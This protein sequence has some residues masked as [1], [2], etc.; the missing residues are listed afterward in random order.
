MGEYMGNHCSIKMHFILVLCAIVAPALAGRLPYIVGGQDVKDPGTYPWQ[1]SLQPHGS[2]HSCGASLVSQ[3]WLVTAAHCVGYS[4]SYYKVVLGMHDK[5]S[6]KNGS[7]V[8][9]D[10][11]QVIMH[12][13]YAYANG[14]PKR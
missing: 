5:D 1:A 10:V 13:D 3:R 12:E 14:F 9:Y 11:D 4:P 6:R 7:P 2:Y 8:M